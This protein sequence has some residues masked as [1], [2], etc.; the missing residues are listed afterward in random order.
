MKILVVDDNRDNVELLRQ[1]LKEEEDYDVIT[2][3][4]GADCLALA[5]EQQPALILLDVQ[6]PE[7]NGF[8]VLERL[9]ADEGTK[10][11]VVIFLTARYKDI[12]RVIKGLELGAFEYLTKPIE[13]EILLAKLRAVA[14]IIRT[15]E[16][17]RQ[18][19]A[20][21]KELVEARTAELT[22]ANDKLRQEI[23]EHKWTEEELQRAKDAAE[24]AR[25]IAE[26][27]QRTS[28]TA[29]QAA[30]A[31]NCAKSE[32]L[33]NMSH[34]LRTPLNGILG[35]AQILTHRHD[36]TELQQERVDIIQRSGN[37]LLLLISDILDLAKI[38]AGRIDI[39]PVPFQFPTFLKNITD[40]IDINA[41]QKQLDFCSEIPSDLPVTVC[42]DE[43]RLRQILLNLLGNAVKFTEKGRVTLRVRKPDPSTSSGHRPGNWE[44]EAS[45]A[46]SHSPAS[47]NTE[48]CFQFHIE[49]TGVGIPP[50]SLQEIFLP[51][52]Q[53]GGQRIQT[54]G[55]GLGLTISQRLA[56]MMGSRIQ[57]Q[58]AVGQGSI[59]RFEVELPEVL[60]RLEEKAVEERTIVGFK[61]KPRNIL[62]ID[63]DMD[64]R[65]VLNSML[66][67]LG[68]TTATAVDGQAG[69][70]KAVEFHPDLILMDL[71][72]P[73]MDG[74]EAIRRIR[75]MPEFN[76]VI[77]VAV[78]ASVHEEIRQQSGVAGG[79]AFIMKPVRIEHLL[80][81][82][83][84]CLHLEWV[85]Q[86]EQRLP[87]DD[88][89]DGEFVLPPAAEL[90]A[91]L[92]LANTGMVVKIIDWA[93]RIEREDAKYRPFTSKI[94]QLNKTFQLEHMRTLLKNLLE[95][96]HAH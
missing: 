30:E 78:S 22:V 55:A 75:H 44:P 29:Q 24:E 28:E 13:D 96:T 5:Q 43:V 56:G 7:M 91:L 68:F 1:I 59:F 62:I 84:R 42:G 27:A 80:E 25:H 61:G 40:I 4:N 10:N 34:E 17:L 9:Q 21:L 48:S 87:E 89:N 36:L 49:D 88:D 38:E 33:A 67:P 12:D 19:R 3:Y 70:A 72:M 65:S 2:A 41:R 86:Q 69:I 92:G 71:K 45:T 32:F 53:M 54:K 20:H 95:D 94:R 58:S 79:D 82:L 63:D 51:F 23:E 26:V 83:E 47:R 35:Y 37:H 73:E 64:C 76:D 60:S 90:H 81:T 31:A 18:H 93:E 14:R 46:V 16:A 57:V 39:T 50:E 85:Y 52:E 8:E 74:F 6:M 15:E 11:I 66:L 77:V